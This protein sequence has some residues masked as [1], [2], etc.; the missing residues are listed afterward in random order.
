MN[1]NPCFVLA[2]RAFIIVAAV[3]GDPTSSLP[4]VQTGPAAWVGAEMAKRDDWILELRPSHVRELEAAVEARLA[5]GES[6]LAAP[7]TASTFPLPT[8]GPI[9]TSMR[10]ELLHGRGFVLLR[11]LPIERY[12]RLETASIFMAIGAHLG[13]ARS[14]NAKGH[15]LG[16]VYDFGLSSSDPHVRL[17]QTN[18]RQTFHTD[19]CDVVGLLCVREAESGGDSLLVSAL[20]VY[21]ELSKS[22]PDLLARLLAP[23]P[24]DRR[25]EVPAGMK[26]F[27]EIPVYS[28]YEGE[29]T[30]FYQ[31]QYFDS[32]QRFPDARHLTDEDVAALDAFDTLANDERLT[33]TMRLTPGDIQFVHNH[34]LLHDRTGF[35]DS[36]APERKRHLLR[37]WLACEGA[38][39]LPPAFAARYGSLEI[40]DRG[41]ISVP[42]AEPRVPLSPEDASG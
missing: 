25:G 9:L 28:W 35:R 41:G 12:T 30:V 24:H 17:Y 31:R 2:S 37:L 18:Q 36:A 29:L 22:R 33:L 26:P 20:T 38:R 32:A 4:P 13:R 42:G 40:G 5:L 39:P 8:L 1:D 23:M 3:P 15:L 6:G 19:S 7:W 27:F 10:Q 21:S 14:Q 16:H 34:T 11:R